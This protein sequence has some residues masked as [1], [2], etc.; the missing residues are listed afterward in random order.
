MHSDLNQNESVKKNAPMSDITSFI[1][2]HLITYKHAGK[3][4]IG[5]GPATQMRWPSPTSEVKLPVMR[6]T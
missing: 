6:N 5:L 2:Y 3:K 1:L 4:Y